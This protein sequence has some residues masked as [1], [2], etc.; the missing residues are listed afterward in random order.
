MAEYIRKKQALDVVEEGCGLCG[1]EIKS[2]EGIEIIFCKECKYF[3]RH[4]CVCVHASGVV[5]PEDDG[6]CNF[7]KAKES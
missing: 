4:S 3:D 5:E 1:E 2:I 7:G 6:F